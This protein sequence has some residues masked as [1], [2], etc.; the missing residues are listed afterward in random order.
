MQRLSEQ[1]SICHVSDLG[2]CARFVI[3]SYRITHLQEYVGHYLFHLWC[4][5]AYTELVVRLDPGS[6]AALQQLCELR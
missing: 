4:K 5:A 1:H 2:A 3:K 6:M